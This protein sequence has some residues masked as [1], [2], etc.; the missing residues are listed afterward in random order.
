MDE[1]KRLTG[2]E[3]KLIKTVLCRYPVYRLQNYTPPELDPLTL[4]WSEKMARMERLTHGRHSPG[5]DDTD[6]KQGRV[7]TAFNECRKLLTL[8]R[9]DRDG[10]IFLAE[11]CEQ[12]GMQDQA[13]AIY[14]KVLARQPSTPHLRLML[15]RARISQNRLEEATALVIQEKHRFGNSGEVELLK[16][17]LAQ[18]EGKY[19]SAIDHYQ[20]A[21]LEFPERWTLKL[22]QGTCYERMGQVAPAR[23]RYLMIWEKADRKDDNG[24]RAQAAVG[25]ARLAV[26]VKPEIESLAEYLA[27]DPDNEPLQYALASAL[28]RA[29]DIEQ[30]REQFEAMAQTLTSDALLAATY[31]RLARLSDNGN[32]ADLLNECLKRDPTHSGAN[33]LLQSL[34]ACHASA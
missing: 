29:G 9:N 14:E 5:I 26:P 20:T 11:I 12:R 18:A 34:E 28:E 8:N 6:L 31:F 23:K 25:L 30:A 16:G 10:L 2:L 24:L 32:R 17:K 13:V 19:E 4:P 27:R 21:S 33:A 7:L 22:D 1:L 15:A 3:Y